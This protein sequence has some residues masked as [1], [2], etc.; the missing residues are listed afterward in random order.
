LPQQQKTK[1]L[2][3][4]SESERDKKQQKRETEP[5]NYRV[6]PGDYLNEHQHLQNAIENI[7]AAKSF[8]LDKSLWL[9]E[10]LL[11]ERLLSVTKDNQSKAAQVMS[12]SEANFRYRLKKFEIKSVREKT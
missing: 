10:K 2:L 4:H 1:N 7:T 11:I 5:P 12:L 9:I 6:M 8:D 3:C